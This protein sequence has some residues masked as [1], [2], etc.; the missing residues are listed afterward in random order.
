MSLS[1]S[2]STLAAPVRQE[3]ILSRKAG[4]TSDVVGLN[5]VRLVSSTAWR[6]ASVSALF[7]NRT[8]AWL[9]VTLFNT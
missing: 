3:E 8:Y 6:V 1:A 9:L 7:A 4:R 5:R 2:R